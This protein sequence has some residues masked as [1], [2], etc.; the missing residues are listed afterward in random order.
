[1]SNKPCPQAILD[2][3]DDD[4]IAKLTT[5]LDKLLLEQTE[6]AAKVRALNASAAASP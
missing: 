1:M 5:Q 2:E 3:E 4:A 6:L